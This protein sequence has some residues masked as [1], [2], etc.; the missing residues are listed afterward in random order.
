MKDWRTWRARN[1]DIE[2][3]ENI[4]GDIYR[5]NGHRGID[6]RV[7]L[8]KPSCTCLD[9]KENK[10]SGGCKHIRAV[11]FTDDTR[12]RSSPGSNFDP[13]DSSAYPND[14]DARRKRVYRRDNWTCQNCK[15]SGGPNGDAKLDAHH[16]VPVSKGGNHDVSNLVTLCRQCH[17]D[18]HGGIDDT[19]RKSPGKN[20][21]RSKSEE[22]STTSN[23]RFKTGSRTHYADEENWSPFV[24]EK[25][26]PPWSQSNPYTYLEREEKESKNV[27]S[28][29]S[30]N[31]RIRKAA[32]GKTT[33]EGRS[34][35]KKKASTRKSKRESQNESTNNSEESVS[36]KKTI[37][38]ESST[39]SKRDKVKRKKEAE[40]K[41]TKTEV[42]I[43]AFIFSIP[44]WLI[45]ELILALLTLNP[46][47]Y[48]TRFLAI[49]V[50]L[51]AIEIYDRFYS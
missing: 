45:V 44:I 31:K 36:E 48:P 40:N 10:P 29:R 41:Y 28:S 39:S 7:D 51:S 27:S 11:S 20:D 49:F 9:W 47:S 8:A 46:W 26:L 17:N 3:K 13:A 24:P 50:S 34:D 2:I 12:K 5:V 43:A 18:A 30:K 15:Q 6:Y 23:K 19:P 33:T 21:S 22:R 25:A 1:H 37:P 32:N 38:D 14:W 4:G 35:S 16:I 42:L